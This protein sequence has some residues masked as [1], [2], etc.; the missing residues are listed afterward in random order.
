[1]EPGVSLYCKRV[2][3][4]AH[5]KNFLPEWL[6]FLRGVIDSADLPLN[7]SRE[8]MQDSALVMK[9]SN[10]VVGRYLKFLGEQA[11]KE[12]EKYKTFWKQFGIYL[13]EGIATEAA[14]S[15]KIA[16]LLRYESSM[17]KAGELASFAE[18]VARMKPGQDTIYYMY[19]TS[20]AAVESSPYLESFKSAGLEVMF[21]YEPSDEFV[22]NHLREFDGKKLASAD[23][24]DLKLD[25]ASAKVAGEP[26]PKERMEGLCKWVK[27]LLGERVREV[28]PSTRLTESPA[29]AMNADRMMTPSMRRLLRL[30]HEREG[31]TGGPETDPQPVN[32]ELNPKHPLVA[33]IDHLRDANP[34]LAKEVVQQLF[35]NAMMAAGFLENPQEMVR[36]IN[37]L[38]EKV[39]A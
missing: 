36:R 19:G 23:S 1:M 4:D 7:I 28:V 11:T 2:L 6:R 30:V 8:S 25:D 3:I 17:T 15:A 5:P 9:L 33:N 29:A 31:N 27:E 21:L 26:L 12:P 34:E 37:K 24:A 14:Q 10:V 13:K 20:R 18:Y 32:F 16:N 22:M 38:L 39:K 35:D